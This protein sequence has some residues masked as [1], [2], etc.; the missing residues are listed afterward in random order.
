MKT[1]SRFTSDYLN[2]CKHIAGFTVIPFLL[3]SCASYHLSD[4]T[5]VVPIN[6]LKHQ[7]SSVCGIAPFNYEP[8]DKSDQ[9]LMTQQDLAKWNEV[10]FQSIN[11]SD[12]CADTIRIDTMQ[13]PKNIDYIIDG[14]L[15]KFYFKKNWVPMLFPLHIGISFFTLS[16]YTWAAG[17]T[18][19]TKVNLEYFANLKDA[20]TGKVIISVPETFASTDVMTIYSRDTENPYGNPGL[21]LSPT[22]NDLAVKLAEAL[23]KDAVVHTI[24]VR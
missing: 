24:P 8:I 17:P 21:A 9:D 1:T 3:S 11:L 16:I 20:K 4:Y 14:T 23:R 15:K 6:K 2:G 18:T 10:F 13:S 12:I 19:S 22:M 7:A 5:P